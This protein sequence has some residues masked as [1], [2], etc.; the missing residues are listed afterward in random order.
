[1][2]RQV[3]M[4][5][6]VCIMLF[7]GGIFGVH[8]PGTSLNNCGAIRERGLQN[9]EAFLWAINTFKTRYPTRLSAFNIGGLAFDSCGSSQKAMQQVC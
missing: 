2:A 3:S 7:L 5:A 9:M 8:S 4:N 6:A 1:M